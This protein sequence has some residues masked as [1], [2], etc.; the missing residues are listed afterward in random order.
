[1]LPAAER[2][3]YGFLFVDANKVKQLVSDGTR[4]V[5]GLLE[6]ARG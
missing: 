6:R 4:P 2:N 1:M 5:R 3:L